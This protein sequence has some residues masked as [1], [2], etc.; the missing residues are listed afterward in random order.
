MRLAGRKTRVVTQ[1]NDNH[2]S[3]D[4]IAKKTLYI[5]ICIQNFPDK[6][7]VL[8]LEFHIIYFPMTGYRLPIFMFL[9][10]TR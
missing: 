7:L 10:L 2:V 8:C 9:K 1:T 5:Y 3:G 6:L 4:T